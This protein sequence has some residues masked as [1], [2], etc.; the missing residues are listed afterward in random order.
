MY[1]S[2]FVSMHGHHTMEISQLSGD[3]S[4]WNSK[5]DFCR[6]DSTP[7]GGTLSISLSLREAAKLAAATEAAVAKSSSFGLLA[8]QDK[9]SFRHW[10]M[11]DA[12]PAKIKL[13]VA[14]VVVYKWNVAARMIARCWR[15]YFFQTRAAT[16]IGTSA[17]TSQIMQLHAEN[18]QLKRQLAQYE[19]LTIISA[20]SCADVP[21]FEQPLSPDGRCSRPMLR[22]TTLRD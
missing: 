2:T 14:D 8:L 9:L 3:N 13:L 4:L 18:A 19:H 11:I 20:P 7:A 17:T 5:S 12:T 21:G 22:N 15:R 16:L 6:Q 1:L 10:S